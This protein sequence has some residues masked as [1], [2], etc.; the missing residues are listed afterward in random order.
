M[1]ITVILGYI[2][3]ILS[4]L[5]FSLFL[6]SLPS[7]PLS[8]FVLQSHKVIRNELFLYVILLCLFKKIYFI[9]VRTLT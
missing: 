7:F 9:V 5:P 3:P 1:R 8:S 6:P 4:F 2:L